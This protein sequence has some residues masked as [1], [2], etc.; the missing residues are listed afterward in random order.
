MVQRDHIDANSAS[1]KMKFMN[2]QH[3]NRCGNIE[4]DNIW[5]DENEHPLNRN[6]A[7]YIDSLSI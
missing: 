4:D 7:S 2:L 6:V 5:W 3:S 1:Q